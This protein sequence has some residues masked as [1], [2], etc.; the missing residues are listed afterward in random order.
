MS[1]ICH[2]KRRLLPMRSMLRGDVIRPGFQ[3]GSVMGQDEVK[4]VPVD[5]DSS[6]SIGDETLS[7][8]ALRW[9]LWWRARL[10][11]QYTCVEI[12]AFSN[13]YGDLLI[14]IV[15]WCFKANSG[16]AQGLSNK[17]GKDHPGRSV[18]IQ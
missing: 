11:E 1:R 3:T 12:H 2:P 9:P 6:Q 7:P 15:P 16:P 10:F 13:P 5:I 4:V 18:D 8:D 17:S 14:A